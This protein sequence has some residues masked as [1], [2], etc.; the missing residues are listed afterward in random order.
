MQ[1]NPY[2]PD[3]ERVPGCS[4]T[5][6]TVPLGFFSMFKS[7]TRSHM[8]NII[9]T[10]YNTL[11]FLASSLPHALRRWLA[12]Y[13]AE[14]I[15]N[16]RFC[17]LP[18][19]SQGLCTQQTNPST[20]ASLTHPPLHWRSFFPPIIPSLFWASFQRVKSLITPQPKEI[21]PVVCW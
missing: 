7:Q 3:S 1:T 6:K 21:C 9:F 8:V 15:V 4:V 14:R 5:R 2:R 17:P 20:W 19:L 16:P 10:S 12:S 11:V 18:L 13:K